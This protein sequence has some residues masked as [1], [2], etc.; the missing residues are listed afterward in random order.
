MYKS[1]IDNYCSLYLQRPLR[2][3]DQALRDRA[4]IAP[5]K[6]E[7]SPNKPGQTEPLKIPK[8]EPAP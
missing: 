5:R 4:D 2:S 1:K 3:L 8:D 6:N 7:P